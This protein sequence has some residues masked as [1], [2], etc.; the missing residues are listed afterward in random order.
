MS[1]ARKITTNTLIA[2]VARVIDTVLA[3]ILIGI[4]T[5]F[6]GREGYGYYTTIF[7]YIYIVISIAHLGLYDIF[8]RDIGKTNPENEKKL[9]SL[10]FSLR[11]ASLALV[12]PCAVLTAFFAPYSSLVKTGI[13]I[14][15]LAAFFMSSYNV[16][17]PIF[18]KHFKIIYV[19][20]AELI[21]RIIYL[22]L[23]AL[24]LI[25]FNSGIIP[26]IWV[27]SI[28]SFINFVLIFFFAR[29]IVPVSLNFHLAN[30]RQ[31]LKESL[32]IGASVIFTL[33]YFRIDTLMLSLMKP[34]ADV[35]IYGLA[36]KILE[37]LIFFPAMFVGFVVPVLSHCFAQKS[38][39][40]KRVFQTTLNILLLGAIPLLVGIVF[41][42]SPVIRLLAGS[43]FEA[44]ASVLQ[45]LAFAISL[46]FLGSLF[47][48]IVIIIKR[49]F[50]AMW[51]YLGGAIFNTAINFY[52]IK[53]YAY[54]GAAFTTFL[55]EFL[56]TL[57][58]IMIVHKTLKYSP[59]FKIVLKAIL[60]S[61]PM[62]LFLYYF[63][64]LNIIL[65]IFAAILIYGSLIY[66]LGGITKKDIKTFLKKA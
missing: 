26:V 64:N 11:I 36:Y 29:Q 54:I 10:I 24:V 53:H 65:L 50:W 22:G 20:I 3:L 49:Q 4:L 12:L 66:L 19:S 9:A 30:W 7:N 45:I 46:I 55:T 38:E 37:N 57:S 33:I 51:V 13:L 59:S 40:F 35:G 44:S 16:L 34:A 43:E 60:A 17:M 18:Q 31:V 41:V 5:R 8:L 27:M 58:L 47:G 63:N 14:G 32:P 39:E 25:K 28:A 62:A 1:L 6:L 56:I 42:A 48:Q 52:F 23:T 61:I 2:S 15:M 21:G